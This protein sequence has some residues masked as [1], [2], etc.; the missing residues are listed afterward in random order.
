MKSTKVIFKN[1]N[2]GNGWVTLGDATMGAG[3]QPYIAATASITTTDLCWFA[4]DV[5]YT[6]ATGSTGGTG[7][8]G[9]NYLG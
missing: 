2:D 1:K 9:S 8:A 7:T 4:M 3:T 5:T 6:S